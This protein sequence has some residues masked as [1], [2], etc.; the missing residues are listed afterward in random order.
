M[1]ADGYLHVGNRFRQCL[2]ALFEGSDGLAL[3]LWEPPARE[4]FDLMSQ[5]S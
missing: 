4:A 1:R 5:R 3:G 2:E